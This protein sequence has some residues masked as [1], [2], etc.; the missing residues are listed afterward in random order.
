MGGMGRAFDGSYA[1]YTCVPAEQVQVVKTQLPWEILGAVPEMLQTAWGSLFKSL[2]LQKG[3]RLLIRGGT[4]SVGFAAA[5]IAKAHGATVASTTRQPGREALLRKSG[6]GHVLIDTGVIAEQV[7]SI[8]DG[9]VDKV[10]DLV[11]AT[12]LSVASHCTSRG[13]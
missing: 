2:R 13:G 11:G 5:A 7:R 10:L 9:G 1:E 4:T 6:A 8:Y 12:T 3:D